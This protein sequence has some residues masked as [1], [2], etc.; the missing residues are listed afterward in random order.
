VGNN[1]ARDASQ[2]T[3][4]PLSVLAAGLQYKDRFALQTSGLTGSRNGS[5]LY[6]LVSSNSGVVVTGF[7]LT[8][9]AT[10]NPG[11]MGDASNPVHALDLSLQL[12]V[13]THVDFL[14]VYEADVVNPAM[15]GV[16]RVTESE[17]PH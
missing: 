8:T 15:Q 11:Q 7:Q 4:T 14:E 6:N 16:L 13:A 2:R 10:M 9:S 5:D 3:A 17:L 12:G 1:G